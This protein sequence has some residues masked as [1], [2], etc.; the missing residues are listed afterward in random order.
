MPFS[1]LKGVKIIEVSAFIAAPLAGLTLAQ[2]G[3]EV[4]RSDP[5]GGGIDASR[6]PLAA[7]GT[8]LYWC[9]LNRAKQSVCVDLKT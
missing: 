9:G 4:I 7:D 8:S 6:W 1:L 2:L 5:V 3:A